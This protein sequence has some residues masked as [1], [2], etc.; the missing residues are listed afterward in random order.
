MNTTKPNTAEENYQQRRETVDA[1][2]GELRGK[3]DVH[4]KRAAADPKNWGYAG[5]LGHVEEVL[6]DLA[7]FMR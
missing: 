4:A 5:D 7:A 6:R 3:L 2:L 1:L